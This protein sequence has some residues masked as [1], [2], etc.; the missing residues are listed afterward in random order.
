MAVNIIGTPKLEPKKVNRKVHLRQ[1]KIAPYVFVLPFIL[2][3]LVFFLYPIIS[4]IIIDF[5]EILRAG[6]CPV[7]WTKKL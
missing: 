1:E 6:R 3:F 2:T 7:Y 4:T 5:Q